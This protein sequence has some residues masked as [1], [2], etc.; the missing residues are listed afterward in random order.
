LLKLRAGRTFSSKNQVTALKQR[1][2]LKEAQ[3]RRKIAQVRH[4]NRLQARKIDS[5]KKGNVN[6]HGS[7]P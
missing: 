3:S 1:S 5:P 6:Q 7:F 2:D 4:V